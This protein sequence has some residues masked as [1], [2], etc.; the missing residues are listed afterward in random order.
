VTHPTLP[1]SLYFPP[2]KTYT[3]TVRFLIGRNFKQNQTGFARA[4]GVVLTQKAS[5]K[6][7]PS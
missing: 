4:T 5:G 6:E 2:G 7:N 1:E 3:V